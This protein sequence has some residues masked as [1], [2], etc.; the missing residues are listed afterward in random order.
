MVPIDTELPDS[1]SGLVILERA[2]E[3]SHSFDRE[4][5]RVKPGGV[6]FPVVA[7]GTKLRARLMSDDACIAAIAFDGPRHVGERIIAPVMDRIRRDGKGRD[8][9]CLIGISGGVDSSYTAY[10]AREMG[11]RPLAVHFDNG[12]NSELAV[13][14]ASSTGSRIRPNSCNARLPANT[15]ATTNSSDHS[16]PSDR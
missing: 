4:T 15:R 12:W 5:R 7:L 11:L 10:L 1:A 14:K 3:Y 8:H 13:E 9:D 16:T 6:E 2:S